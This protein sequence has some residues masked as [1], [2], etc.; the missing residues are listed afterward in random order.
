MQERVYI[1]SEE[2]CIKCRGTGK[3]NVYRHDSEEFEEVECECDL[4][5]PS[6]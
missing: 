3:I 1:E 5:T 6:D 2:K 4:C